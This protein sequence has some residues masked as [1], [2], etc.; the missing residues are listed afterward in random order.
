[1]DR[2]ICI[3]GKNLIAIKGLEYFLKNFPKEKIF[4]IP[5]K[6]DDGQNKWQ[7]SFKKFAKDNYVKEVNIQKVCNLKNL[8]FFSMEFEKI[9]IPE[10]FAS[11]KLF[12]IHFSLLPKY[13]GM[14]KSAHPLMN[15]EVKSGVTIHKIDK[16]IDTGDIIKQKE[17]KIDLHDTAES[18]YEKYIF[19]S[20]ELFN[21]SI[22]EILDD[23]YKTLKQ[24][25]IN[26]SYYSKK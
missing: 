24:S 23:K 14:Y 19:C 20:I 1:M 15:G 13:K 6:S 4:F 12:N 18:L 3:S 17:F 22:K 21:N 9:I 25:P 2:V 8:I 5:N 10:N 11:N 26:L 16:G 7:P